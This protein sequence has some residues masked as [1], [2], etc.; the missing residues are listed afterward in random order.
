MKIFIRAAALL[1]LAV[2]GSALADAQD[3]QGYFSIMGSYFDDDKERGV[4]DG[5]S[6]GQF[7]FG[8]AL[9]EN[10][11]VEGLYMAGRGKNSLAGG[12]EQ[13]TGIGVDMQRVFSRSARFSPYLHAGVG[14]FRVDP[15]NADDRDG[16]MLSA[17][18]GFYLD[19]GNPNVALRGEWRL[20]K[21]TASD[22]DPEDQLVSLGLQFAFGDA[23][24]VTVDS[25]NDGVSD[26]LD[27]C[28]GT[29][30]GV[31]V[32]AYG[33]ELDSDGDGVGDTQDACPDTPAGASVDSKGCELDSD[34]DGVV[35]RL[36]ECPNTPAGASVDSKG[37]ELDTDGDG[38][39]DRLDECPNT[40]E[41]TPVNDRGCPI[42]GEYIL[43]GVS[44]ETNSDRLLSGA[45]DVLD[46]VIATLER[47]PDIRFEVAGHTDSDGPAAYNESLS[48]RRAQ[49]VHDYLAANGISVERM[50]V[51]GYGESRPIADNST[52]AGKALNRR[53][54]LN[55]IE[56]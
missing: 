30:A 14:Y 28:P 15:Q 33:C 26:G 12:D 3:G 19:L 35:D 4:D 2:S 31:A 49:T 16:R 24:T 40:P 44:F 42:Q 11:N 37:C 6:G 5:I 38:V 39:V 8:Y 54:S 7:G 34:G 18:L 41:G 1:A 43:E 13:Y 27:R 51:R 56:D 46:R 20:R 29:P 48:T 55:V 36:D 32:D 21:E 22:N 45:T 25:D 23:G 9:N 10:W 50:T 52:A 53:V 17:G 47:Y